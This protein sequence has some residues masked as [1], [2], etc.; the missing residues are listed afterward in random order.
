VIGTEHEP[1]KAAAAQANFKK[2]GLSGLIDLRK[3]DLRETLKDLEGPIDFALFDI[4]TEMAR[5]GWS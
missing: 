4:W 1:T 3:G 2:A 5:P